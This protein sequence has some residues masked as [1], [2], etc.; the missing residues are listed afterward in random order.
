MDVARDL[1][2]RQLADCDGNESGRVDDL[3][4]EWDAGAAHLGALESGTAIVLEQCGALGRLLQRVGGA[5]A[6]RS[7]TIEWGSV[8]R[9]ERTRV[10]LA[11]TPAAAGDVRLREPRRRRYSAVARLPV[12]D[13]AGDRRSVLDIRCETA[14]GGA[15]PRVL[16]LIACRHTWLRTL[17]MKRYDAAGVPLADVRSHARFVPWSAVAEVGDEIRLRVTFDEL[18][19]PDEVPDPGP[20]PWPRSDPEAP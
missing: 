15:A 6:R 12:I 13:A 7:R 8:A 17:G 16:G 10:L 19:R 4:L 20:P 18:A 5:R 9:V 14:T 3:W 11:E 1:V 2:D